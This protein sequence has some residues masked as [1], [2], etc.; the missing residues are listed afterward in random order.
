MI[1]QWRGVRGRCLGVTGRGGSLEGPHCH[2]CF[3]PATPRQTWRRAE[4]GE[5]RREFLYGMGGGKGG[6]AWRRIGSVPSGRR[7]RWPH[8]RPAGHVEAIR[9][10]P[11]TGRDPAK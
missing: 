8:A 5:S 9:T 7:R 3:P 4:W 1:G 6:A 2:Q 10:V 11:F